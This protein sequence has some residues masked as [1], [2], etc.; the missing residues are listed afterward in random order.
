MKKVTVHVKLNL[1]NTLI[2]VK[3][4]FQIKLF[5]KQCV[6]LLNL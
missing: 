6:L 1:Y 2:Y 4:K 3:L 5:L